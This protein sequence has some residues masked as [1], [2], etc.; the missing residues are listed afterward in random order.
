MGHKIILALVSQRPGTTWELEMRLRRRFPTSEYS[1]SLVRQTLSRLHG[2][3]L[4]ERCESEQADRRGHKRMVWEATAEGA[5]RSRAWV[6]EDVPEA[7]AREDLQ[8]RLAFCRA[9]D[10]PRLLELVR[11]EERL[12]G[13]R[14]TEIGADH[15]SADSGVKDIASG[16]ERAWWRSRA[17]WFASVRGLI[18]SALKD[19]GSE[20]DTSPHEDTST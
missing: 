13:E 20:E 1:R 3:G 18:A 6:L 9:E 11:E 7:P 8:A 16:A 15:A 14:L 4:V 12:C 19:E 10:L 5:Q 17:D 2:A